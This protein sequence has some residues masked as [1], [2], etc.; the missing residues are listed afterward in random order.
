MRETLSKHYCFQAVLINETYLKWDLEALRRQ[1]NVRGEFVRQIENIIEGT[2]E[3]ETDH[4]RAAMD[5]GLQALSEN[6][7]V[8]LR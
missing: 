5:Y 7:E 3:E 1:Q 2:A 6:Q 4:Y 8:K